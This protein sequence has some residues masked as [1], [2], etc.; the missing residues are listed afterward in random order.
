MDNT[1]KSFFVLA[2][3]DN[4]SLEDNSLFYGPYIYSQHVEKTY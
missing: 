4:N 2:C 1:V 3:G